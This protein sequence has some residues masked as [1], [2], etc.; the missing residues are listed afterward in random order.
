MLIVHKITSVPS[1]PRVW[2]RIGRGLVLWSAK[3]KV[4]LRGTLVEIGKVE[5]I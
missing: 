3:S 5:V 2:G 4:K 1:K